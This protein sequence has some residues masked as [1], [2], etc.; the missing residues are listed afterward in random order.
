MLMMVTGGQC[1]CAYKCTE[2]AAGLLEVDLF[3]LLLPEE[4]P[5]I[6]ADDN[7]TIF[8]HSN[9]TELEDK[10]NVVIEKISK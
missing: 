6:F 7:N 1:K 5:T 4:I 3:R 9:P 10:I 8:S 2:L